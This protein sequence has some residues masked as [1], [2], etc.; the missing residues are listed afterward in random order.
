LRR[1]AKADLFKEVE[2]R[3]LVPCSNTVR[4][5]QASLLTT[6]FDIRNLLYGAHLFSRPRSAKTTE[7]RKETYFFDDIIQNR[8]Y[9]TN[10]YRGG[11]EVLLICDVHSYPGK[12]KRGDKDTKDVR[13]I[14]IRAVRTRR[15][16]AIS[17]APL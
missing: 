7:M 13:A 17:K 5:T 8:C 12:E 10:V 2:R 1:C 9:L 3:L 14:S 11:R 6:L 15:A 16:S 4:A